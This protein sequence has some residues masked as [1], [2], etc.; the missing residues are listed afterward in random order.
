VLFGDP[1]GDEVL[2]YC[3]LPLGSR[4]MCGIF[5]IVGELPSELAAKCV[6]RMAHRGPDGRGLWH[7]RGVTLGHRRLAILDLSDSGVQP[8]SAAE[9]RYWIT[10][11][12]E[13]YN[14][15]ELRDELERC[16]HVFKT[17]TDTEVVIASF[18]EW[19]E[20]CL[21]RFNGMWAFAIWDSHT[22]SLFLSRDR[23][24]KKPLFYASTKHG[25][26]FAS[27]MKALFPL[28]T[29]V[30]PNVEL[31]RDRARLMSYESTAECVIQGISRFPAGH[32]GWFRGGRLTMRRWWCTL[33]H[34][35][36]VPTRYEEQVEHLRELFLDACRVRMRSDV[37]LGTALSGGLD[38]SATICSMAQIARTGHTERQGNDWQHAFV[39]TFP[40]TPLDESEFA[41]LVANH[42]G[43]RA[44]LIPI[45]PGKAIAD[46]DRYFWLFE[47]LYITSPIPF[48]VTYAAVKAAGISVTLDG[49]GADELFG[50][51]SF[52]YLFALKDAGFNVR[53]A[54]RIINTYRDAWPIG[55][56]QFKDIP[57][58]FLFW[59]RWHASRARSTL[60]DR[61]QAVVPK[62]ASHPRWAE[63]DHLTRRLYAS[64]HETVLPTLL[65]N[66]DRY[67]MA[68]GVEIRMPFLDYR[69][70]CFAFALPWTS[71]LRNGF[72][73][74][75]VRDAVAPYMP[76]EIAYRKTKIG[77]NSPVVDW[78]KGPL[79]P[80]LE[81]VTATQD[82]RNC[83]LIDPI[84]TAAAVR[85]VIYSPD[86][87]FQEGER[88]WTMLSPYLWEQA[89]IRG[90][91]AAT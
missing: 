58:P 34:L 43:I 62:D 80:F 20:A 73:K 21:N 71:K 48:V 72:S 60:L 17:R 26:S 22:G 70:A 86:A 54:L 31:V 91:G 10:F 1:T 15:V 79:R 90:H 32:L 81:H 55:S 64:T 40:G 44:A 4:D 16:G 49:H 7:G 68:N 51:Y 50:G 53:E 59:L 39:A 65:R 33:D 78:M 76:Q 88:A 19:G 45:D 36:E 9:G 56:S 18:V 13:I 69:V 28:L 46:L 23:F 14:F 11:N 47:D 75:I 25:F 8:M 41:S 89:V 85:R 52:D 63:L 38:S 57:A 35:P 67:S 77:F 2:P 29:D 24:G 42:I 3:N 83:V 5:G 82:F 84:A 74:A 61:G 27:E 12:G 87:T 66:Y 6:D 30:T 37:P